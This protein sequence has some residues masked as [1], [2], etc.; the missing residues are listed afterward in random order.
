MVGNPILCVLWGHVR[1]RSVGVLSWSVLRHGITVYAWVLAA[2][3]SAVLVHAITGAS[4]AWALVPASLVAAY[5]ALRWIWKGGAP[6]PA[7]RVCAVLC[8]AVGLVLVARA[9]FASGVSA[10]AGVDGLLVP[11]GSGIGALGPRAVPV[12]AV[13]RG[14]TEKVALPVL[15]TAVAGTAAR[16][17]RRL[18]PVAPPAPLPPRAITLAYDVVELLVCLVATPA[19]FLAGASLTDASRGAD[20]VT[21]ALIASAAV[22][23]G[24]YAFLR[25]LWS[26][27]PTRDLRTFL[28]KAL[29]VALLAGVGALTLR[30]AV[31]TLNSLR[32]AAGLT[33]LAVWVAASLAMC[34]L[35]LRAGAGRLAGP[36]ATGGG[37]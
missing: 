24:A 14:F 16:A 8:G 5:A 29:L 25:L 37:G 23:L 21:G 6:R 3:T 11:L 17:A 22:P 19:A 10:A 9:G 36:A 15:A 35:R 34:G 27:I 4:G 20:Q 28:W 30:A 2:Y 12:G 26:G 31:P 32:A 13:L 1:V 7:F 18:P 33:V